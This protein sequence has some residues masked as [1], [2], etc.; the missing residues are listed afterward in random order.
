[1]YFGKTPELKVPFRP[2]RRRFY[3]I[4]EERG[5]IGGTEHAYRRGKTEKIKE[6]N[7]VNQAFLEELNKNLILLNEQIWTK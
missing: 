6:Q 1:M 5:A 2:P 7:M 4:W 3:P